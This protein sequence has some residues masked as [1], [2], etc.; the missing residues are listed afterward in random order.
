MLQP[1][2]WKERRT[3]FH[4]EAI[5]GVAA[6]WVASDAIAWGQFARLCGAER[7]TFLIA[8]LLGLFVL[9]MIVVARATGLV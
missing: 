4:L 6:L 1:G 3:V 8:A 9:A 7:R 5:D 2:R